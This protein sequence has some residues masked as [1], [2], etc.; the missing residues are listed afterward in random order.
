ML[1]QFCTPLRKSEEGSDSNCFSKWYPNVSALLVKMGLESVLL[2]Y[3]HSLAVFCDD[4]G[5]RVCSCFIFILYIK[6]GII[7]DFCKFCFFVLNPIF[8]FVHAVYTF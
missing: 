2:L 4:L 6:V 1:Q 5:C 3:S 8:R 7:L